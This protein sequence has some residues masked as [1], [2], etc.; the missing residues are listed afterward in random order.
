MLSVSAV[1]RVALRHSV[2]LPDQFLHVTTDPRQAIAQLAVSDLV[3][4]YRRE[5]RLAE[6]AGAMVWLHSLRALSTPDLR[7]LGRQMWRELQRGQAHTAPYLEEM[8][9]P[10]LSEVSLQNTQVPEDLDPADL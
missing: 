3:R 10:P 2:L 4:R 8:R 7:L 1:V 9:L 6:A 5:G